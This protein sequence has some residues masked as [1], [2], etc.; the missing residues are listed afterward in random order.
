MQT[1]KLGNYNS[2]A[3]EFWVRGETWKQGFWGFIFLQFI[4]R[5]F[6][7]TKIIQRRMIG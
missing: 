3:R 1:N 7:V 2:V 4:L 5:F 6:S